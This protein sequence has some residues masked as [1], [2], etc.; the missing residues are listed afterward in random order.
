M[1]DTPNLGSMHSV[2]GIETKW[3]FLLE[4]LALDETCAPLRRINTN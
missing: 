2:P 1:N 3:E 4:V